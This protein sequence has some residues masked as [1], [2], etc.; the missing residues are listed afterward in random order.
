MKLGELRKSG[1]GE[2]NKTA[3]C[4]TQRDWSSDR[5]EWSLIQDNILNQ[6]ERNE[7]GLDQQ[8][9]LGP[10]MWGTRV[11]IDN[12]NQYVFQIH[13]ALTI[14]TTLAVSSSITIFH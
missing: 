14:L 7:Y 2:H 8:T 3:F 9:E 5:N 12:D 6:L 4:D 1:Y 11:V 13:E 10:M